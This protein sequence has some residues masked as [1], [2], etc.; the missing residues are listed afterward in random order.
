MVVLVTGARSG[1]GKLAA[2]ELARRGHTVYGGL[3]DPD[4]A[5]PLMDAAQ[6]L[7]VRPIA[8]DVTDGDQ[9][10]AAVSS[11]LDAHGRIDGLVN[12]AGIA[13]GGFLEQIDDAGLRRLF[14]VN[15]FGVHALTQRVLPAMRSQRS[16]SV[17][18][19]SSMSGRAAMPGL[20]AYAASKFALEGMSEA[21]RHEL[22]P[23]G[24][25][26]VLIEPGPYKTDIFGR[27]RQEVDDDPDS[28]YAPFAER[29]RAKVAEA[30]ENA[31]D[32]Q[33]VAVAIAEAVEGTRTALR[34]PMGPNSR[35]RR[36]AGLLP[37]GLT[38]WAIGRVMGD[39]D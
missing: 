8:L 27:N 28:P 15:V 37:F 23:F 3:R 18:M 17:V 19:V 5:G 36:V 39:A 21:W 38:E 22:R 30:V 12:N 9:R 16:G 34:Y 6:G 2:V 33:D 35:V 13:L 7:D 20:G 24:V 1:F 11:I 25:R 10:Q 4:T 26:V 29:M 14:E 32:P 31:G